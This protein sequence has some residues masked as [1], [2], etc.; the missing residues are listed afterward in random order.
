MSKVTFEWHGDELTRRV[1]HAAREAVNET[2]DEARDDAKAAHPWKPSARF[3]SD[4][5]S[6]IVSEHAH[7]GPNPTAAFG[8]TRRKG[9]YGLFHEEG[10]VHEHT[11]PALRP[12]A[13]RVFP[14]LVA[15]IKEKLK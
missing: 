3:P 11:Y 6:Q 10:T 5:E 15:K 13:D 4:L 7:A 2:V 1:E 14:T 12:A 8:Y 9:F